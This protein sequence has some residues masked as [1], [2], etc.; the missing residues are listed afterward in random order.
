MQPGYLYVSLLQRRKLDLLNPD[1]RGQR[2]G[3]RQNQSLKRQGQSGS[4]LCLNREHSV[5][6][7]QVGDNTKL[8]RP[9]EINVTLTH[10]HI[11]IW[12]K[13]R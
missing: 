11:H 3:T 8:E 12:V 4:L 1:V 7:K 5:T 9:E 10:S 6:K 13:Y 2:D